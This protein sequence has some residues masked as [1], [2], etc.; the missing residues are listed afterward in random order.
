MSDCIP[1]RCPLFLAHKT[2]F[3]LVWL[4]LIYGCVGNGFMPY[5][6]GFWHGCFS[7]CYYLSLAFCCYCTS[8]LK[9]LLPINV[10]RSPNWP[11]S[12]LSSPL[13]LF[14]LWLSLWWELAL[15][16]MSYQ[17]RFEIVFHLWSLWLIYAPAWCNQCCCLATWAGI[18]IVCASFLQWPVKFLQTT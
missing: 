9:R 16:F 10:F 5:F 3:F 8:C 11:N 17:I 13:N 18:F 2:L 12:M 6:C 15:W 7:S 14:L 4:F 1:H